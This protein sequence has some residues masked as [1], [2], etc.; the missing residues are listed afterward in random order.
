M[1]FSRGVKFWVFC[2]SGEIRLI[3]ARG[4]KFCGCSG[5]GGNSVDFWKKVEFCRIL[6]KV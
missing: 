4:V 6:Q 2:K 1:D 5:R 3:F